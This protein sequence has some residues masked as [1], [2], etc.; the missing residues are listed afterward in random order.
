MW[1]EPIKDVSGIPQK[2]GTF[3]AKEQEDVTSHQK[4]VSTCVGAGTAGTSW[5]QATKLH[6]QWI[7]VVLVPLFESGLLTGGTRSARTVPR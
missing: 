4:D 3:N 2:S 5:L 1:T 6:Y 7:E